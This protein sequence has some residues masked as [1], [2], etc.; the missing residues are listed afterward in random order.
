[1]EGQ[2]GRRG[3]VSPI[4][5]ERD[6]FAVYRLLEESGETWKVEAVFFPKVDFEAWLAAFDP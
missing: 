3:D 4:L 1:M 6:R 5:S 2:L